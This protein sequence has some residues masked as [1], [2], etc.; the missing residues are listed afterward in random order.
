M[1]LLAAWLVYPALL[2]VVALG[3]GLLVDRAAGRSLPGALLL[4]VGVALTVALARL[5]VATS[6]TAR[7]ALPVIVV[8][9]IAGLVLGLARLR[10]LRPSVWIAAPALGVFL[11]AGAPM[12]LSGHPTF[13]GYTSLPDT[14][15]QLT[16][17]WLF[18]HHGPDWQAL[19]MGSPRL[20]MLGY[21]ETA[22][23]AAG[24]AVLGVTGPLGLVDLAWLYQP[25]LAVMVAMMALAIGALIATAVREPWLRAL[26]AF[27]AAQPALVISFV[28][29]GSI[30]EIA[31]VSLLMTAVAVTAVA[32]REERSTRALLPVAVAGAAAFGALGPAAGPY[33]AVLAVAIL[34]LWVP[35]LRRGRPA[36]GPEIAWLGAGAALGVVLAA[37]VLADLSAVLTAT[38]GT[39]TQETDLGNLAGPLNPVQAFGVWLNGDFRYSPASTPSLNFAIAGAAVAACFLGLLWALRSRAGSVLL[40]ALVFVPV[41][42][43][44][45][46]RGSPY[47]D[48][49]V[50]AL[51]SPALLLLAGFG[52][53]SLRRAGL[54]IESFALAAV[55]AG[56]VLT[57]NALAYH[58]V[59]LAP[60]DRYE[61]LLDFN[62]RLAGR[63]PVVFNEYDE[64]AKYFLR[65]V[66]V[67]SQPEFPHGY[68]HRPYTPNALMDPKRKP[69]MK[70]PLD[71]DDLRLEYQESVPFIILRRS[72]A[73]SRP[74]ANF[75]R[76]LVGRYYE[77][78]QRERTPQVLAHRVLGPDVFRPSAEP[79]CDDVRRLAGQARD[80]GAQL[81][82]VARGPIAT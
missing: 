59:S 15:H 4:P 81:A 32:A 43:Y 50:F 61:E 60:Y 40:A 41:S 57:S 22:Y 2:L 21:V 36:P 72:P 53:V 56:G 55:L 30:K 54:R 63:G 9:A 35:R 12:F 74:P 47:A 62:D 78:W 70:T 58:D 28:L 37:P 80:A 45:V 13:A 7:L 71:P 19:P 38:S 69:S 51:V 44:L 46:R 31:A 3:L 49:K 77:L 17:A 1:A 76:V 29:Q 14:S 82:Y 68:R 67:N 16:L 33:L 27:L 39:L 10:A 11:I 34:V 18:A 48:A 6:A 65:D 23:P 79:R 66:P 25:L 64:F 8:L 52:I 26:I 42:V 24:Q 20:S 75:R 5:I 73:L